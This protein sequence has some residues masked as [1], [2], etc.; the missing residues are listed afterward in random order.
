MARPSDET[1][2]AAL[3]DRFAAWRYVAVTT[4]RRKRV[5]HPIRNFPSGPGSVVSERQLWD[6]ET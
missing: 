6:R 4:R 1:E 2:E 3:E 5:L